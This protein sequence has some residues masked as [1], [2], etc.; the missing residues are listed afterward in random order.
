MFF[1]DI[2]HTANTS[3]TLD[4]MFPVI[5]ETVMTAG[6]LLDKEITDTVKTHLEAL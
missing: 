5:A 3:G 2:S 4:I 1:C 6:P